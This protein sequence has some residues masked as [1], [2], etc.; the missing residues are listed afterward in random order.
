MA[1][2]M[3]SIPWLLGALI[4]IGLSALIICTYFRLWS[5]VVL[6][7]GTVF[8]SLIFLSQSF[9]LVPFI[10]SVLVPSSNSYGGQALSGAVAD[11]FAS[12]VQ[13]T[14]TGNVFYPLIGYFHRTIA[15]DFQWELA[16]VYL[17]F[18][19]YIAVLGLA[20]P[21]I[22]VYAWIKFKKSNNEINWY[23]YLG[24]WLAFLAT[25]FLFTVNI[26]FFKSVFIAMGQIPGFAMFRNSYDKFA[27]AYIFVFSI[28]FYVSLHTYVKAETNKKKLAAVLAGFT[29]LILVN[30]VPA[31]QLINR[32]L[33]TTQ[34]SFTTIDY[35]REY[36][37]FMEAI[38]ED[39]PIDS[40]ILSVPFGSSS[41]T[42]VK[43]ESSNNVFAGRSPVKIL[44][45]R[46]DFS[47]DL[48][49]DATTAQLINKYIQSRDYRKL[50]NVLNNH[51]VGYIVETN[52]IPEEVK[53]SY[54]FNTQTFNKQDAQFK[55]AL[56]GPLV[57]T[58]STGAY[59]LYSINGRSGIAT[60]TTGVHKYVV[61]STDYAVNDRYLFEKDG[62]LGFA[63]SELPTASTELISNAFAYQ[64]NPS[65]TIHAQKGDYLMH[66]DSPDIASFVR[67]RTP[68]GLGV[69]RD[70]HYYIEGKKDYKAN[71]VPVGVLPASSGLLVDDIPVS[72]DKVDGYSASSTDDV[73]TLNLAVA[74]V[75]GS[76][77][78]FLNSSQKND[79]NAHS[80]KG[81]KTAFNYNAANA[82]MVLTATDKHLAC[83]WH[84]YEASPDAVYQLRFNYQTN[85]SNLKVVITDENG[86]QLEAKA[87]PKTA[88][89]FANYSGFINVSSRP[90]RVYFYSGSSDQMAR[91]E[92]KDLQLSAYAPGVKI[93]I[94]EPINKLPDK[95]A[96]T[97]PG[98]D[99][100]AVNMTIG[101]SATDNKVSPFALWHQS[102][103]NAV[104]D[105]D[106][107][108]SY[109][110]KDGGI[111]LRSEK[112][113]DA[114]IY[115]DFEIN[116]NDNYQLD[117]RYDKPRD[118]STYVYIGFGRGHKP[119]TFP[120]TNS[121]QLKAM[122]EPPK[123]AA[124]MRLY[125]YSGHS[126]SQNEITYK[127]LN[128][129]SMAKY[130]YRN[131]LVS[132]IGNKEYDVDTSKL[133][134]TKYLMTAHNID[135]A[136]LLNLSEAFHPG[137]ELSIK[138]RKDNS[139]MQHA[140]IN[141]YSNG[142]YIDINKLCR[143]Q[144]L[145]TQ[146]ANGSYDMEMVA[147]FKPQ[148][149]FHVGSIISGATLLGCIGYL[150]YSW[151]RRKQKP[152]EETGE[153]P[154]DNEPPTDREPPKAPPTPPMP[155][156]QVRRRSMDMTR[157][158]GGVKRL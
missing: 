103:C 44:S 106:S 139:A 124:L 144:K 62:L 95:I 19:D 12:T 156:K 131:S 121:G 152:G 112:K 27:L 86:K 55:H 148:R 83:S 142:W 50:K 147:E 75:F 59:K 21:A 7:R 65:S 77:L 150:T 34:K 158:T 153:P 145:C 73:R 68:A 88:N 1:L 141:Q 138:G 93:N 67:L 85:A 105:S 36:V 43:D 98:Q 53:K 100:G 54:L 32:P 24:L 114:C 45:G 116:P 41:Y 18:Y 136:F 51:N 8:L 90:F 52:N 72:P 13:A 107:A 79:C 118:Q 157:R 48:S 101:N 69:K 6:I 47:G 151:R 129:S 61:N 76:T 78:N 58:S 56:Y 91:T 46:N 117:L 66:L 37:D 4:P 84:E 154:Q 94:S 57:S 146:N 140:E 70:F 122:I 113:H 81:Q 29:I 135:S 89:Q 109:I 30:F 31:K 22:F 127:S 5:K 128:I 63:N 111:Q 110:D 97:V 82:S 92:Y 120:L 26:G 137:W 20:F 15:F 133:S 104:N 40:N 149:W 108:V 80:S 123:S 14:S 3:Y 2:A 28:L 10:N 23:V 42:I 155:Q 35:P 143:G 71:S 87:L 99:T 96:V 11:T 39:V 119:V 74:N 134:P 25:L 64:I 130:G 33:W 125:L 17:R 9:W 16:S 60:A 49:F 115:N 38:K 126:L 102:N 132:V